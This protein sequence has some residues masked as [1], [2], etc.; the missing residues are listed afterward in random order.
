M[1]IEFENSQEIYIIWFLRSRAALR[2]EYFIRSFLLAQSIDSVFIKE[3]YI[4][5][6]SI[7][8]YSFTG[9]SEIFYFPIF[10][11]NPAFEKILRFHGILNVICFLFPSVLLL[12][13]FPFH[14]NQFRWHFMT[15]SFSILKF[16]P[17][18]IVYPLFGQS[19]RTKNSHSQSP[20]A[21]NN[22]N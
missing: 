2:Y 12:L 21:N 3:R 4:Y 9:R 10:P 18:V 22:N 14:L 16:M 13:L 17:H 20:V 8:N 5:M 11:K 7:F 15:C 19:E 6:L 1:S